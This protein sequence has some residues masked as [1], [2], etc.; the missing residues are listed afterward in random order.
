M[1]CSVVVVESS[2]LLWAAE[3]AGCRD[4][5]F[6]GDRRNVLILSPVFAPNRLPYCFL[7]V[8]LAFIRHFPSRTP[9]VR[10]QTRQCAAAAEAKQRRRKRCMWRARGESRAGLATLMRQQDRLEGRVQNIDEHITKLESDKTL[11]KDAVS[12]LKERVRDRYQRMHSLLEA[13]QCES[14][15]MLERTYRTYRRKNSQ[16]VLQLN[17]RRQQ[18]EKLLSSVQ[19]FFQRAADIN[20]MKNTKPYQLLIDRSNLQLSSSVPPLLVGQISA[21]HFFSGLSTEEKNLRKILEEPINDAS[22]LEVVQTHSSSLGARS[23]LKKRKYGMAFLESATENSTSQ[24]PPPFL[25]TNKMP[26]LTEPSQRDS[27]MFSDVLGQNAHSGQGH[28]HFLDTSNHH[29]MGQHPGAIFSS[30]LRGGGV[31][32]QAVYEGRK[33][34]MCS[35]PATARPL[36]P[37]HDSFAPINS[38]EY[39]PIPGSQ[40]LQHLPMRGLIEASQASRGPDYFGLYSQ[41]ASKHYGTK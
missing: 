22:I 15:Q 17:E 9:A 26:L 1:S 33:V 16:Q 41:S 25:Y 2:G 27:N 5:T 28:S 35:R 39:G 37:T 34:L 32:Q 21:H 12:D 29:V 8:F 40:P 13:K 6:A 38:Q 30:H 19:A 11:M 20:F 23:G 3:E 36:Y 7:F 10:T 24:H 18:A 14:I 31:S 4:T